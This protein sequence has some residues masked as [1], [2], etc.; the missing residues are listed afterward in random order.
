M[1]VTDRYFYPT[2]DTAH[3]VRGWGVV[4]MENLVVLACLRVAPACFWPAAFYVLEESVQEEFAWEEV[5]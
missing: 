2:D 1:L 5:L 4:A 3:I